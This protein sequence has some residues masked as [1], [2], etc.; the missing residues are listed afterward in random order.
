M[1]FLDHANL[2]TCMCTCLCISMWAC[3]V[4]I[5]SCVPGT[6]LIQVFTVSHLFVL[7]WMYNVNTHRCKIRKWCVPGVSHCFFTSE[8]A[9]KFKNHPYI[10]TPTLSMGYCYVRDYILCR[11]FSLHYFSLGKRVFFHCVINRVGF[12]H[13]LLQ[14]MIHSLQVSE[15]NLKLGTS[16]GEKIPL[17]LSDTK[18]NVVSN[19]PSAINSAMLRCP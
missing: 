6:I 17:K 10:A 15:E 3:T 8:G 4:Q 12:D 18:A 19:F 9:G 1:T 14:Y 5:L 13:V 11:S 2:I 7:L 16:L